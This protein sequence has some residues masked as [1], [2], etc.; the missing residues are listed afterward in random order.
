M[1]IYMGLDYIS[2]YLKSGHLEGGVDFSE[3]K[4]EDFQALL[5]KE[6]NNEELTEEEMD[7]LNKYKK[8]IIGGCQIV[9][10]D[11][12]IN[13]IGDYNWEDCLN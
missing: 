2:G 3:E 7:R 4:E 11:Y 6:L 8:R 13:D 5:E 9:V 1:K 10:D 12:K